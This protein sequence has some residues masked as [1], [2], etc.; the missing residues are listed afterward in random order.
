MFSNACNAIWDFYAGKA[1]AILERTIR[2]ACDTIGNY[3]TSEAAA[4]IERG[5]SNA[6]N[7]IRN[8]YAGKVSISERGSSNV[9]NA[10]W[11]CNVSKPGALIERTT[12]YT[13]GAFFY[14]D[15]GI[16]RHCSFVLIKH[17]P[18][19]HTASGLAV[20]PCCTFERG[21]SNACYTIRDFNACK[22]G[23]IIEYRISYACYT[24]RDYNAGKTGATI[25][26]HRANAGDAI[27]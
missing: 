27:G 19:I 26:R 17:F 21:R 4:T 1:G 6:C 24:I 3:N 2:N 5:S 16:C 13:Q 10:I 11:D 14:S 20:I 7:A 23:A 22:T 18:H 12:T 8:F 9:C 25:E 15:R